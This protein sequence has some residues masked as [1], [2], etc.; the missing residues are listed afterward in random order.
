MI[1]VTQN[2]TAVK[3][4]D[5]STKM[6]IFCVEIVLNRQKSVFVG[7]AYIPIVNNDVLNELELSVDKVMLANA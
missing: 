2:L 5:L 4:E 6:E 7:T 3:R 1:A